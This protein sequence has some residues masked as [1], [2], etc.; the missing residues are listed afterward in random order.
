M[1]IQ[2]VLREANMC[3]DW[4]ANKVLEANWDLI[5]FSFPDSHLLNMLSNDLV[6]YSNMSLFSA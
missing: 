4:V 1:T 2:H 5:I 6:G 3:A